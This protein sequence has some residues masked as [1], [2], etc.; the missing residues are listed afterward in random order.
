M[1]AHKPVTKGQCRVAPIGLARRS[2]P[3]PPLICSALCQT[4]LAIDVGR[5]EHRPRPS[6]SPRT[7][8]GHLGARGIAD[9]HATGA[10]HH[11]AWIAVVDFT[12]AG[13]GT[14]EDA[15]G[16]RVTA[17]IAVRRSRAVDIAVGTGFAAPSSAAVDVPA[18]GEVGDALG[19]SSTLNLEIAGASR[20]RNA[21]GLISTS[22]GEVAEIA[23]IGNAARAGI[24]ALDVAIVGATD[25]AWAPTIAA[26]CAGAR[27][28]SAVAPAR[29][30][31][32]TGTVNTVLADV[33]GVI[34]APAI[35]R[36]PMNIGLAAIGGTAVAVIPA[37]ATGENALAPVT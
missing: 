26:A 14:S 18:V 13:V 27:K 21:S 29:T 31:T 9:K 1:G 33:A 17:E 10:G 23:S 22:D 2:P 20:V 36:V 15:L 24:S 30:R 4:Y 37:C 32:A 16:V 35:R 12:L 7:K 5:C 6:P 8:A 25:I 3:P 28:G 34:A 19:A 11:R